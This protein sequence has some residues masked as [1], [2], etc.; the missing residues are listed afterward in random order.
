MRT[1]R[2]KFTVKRNKKSNW[3]SFAIKSKNANE[4]SWSFTLLYINDSH[5]RS[6]EMSPNDTWKNMFWYQYWYRSARRTFLDI[7][8]HISLYRSLS[9]KKPDVDQY[10]K[11]EKQLEKWKKEKGDPYVVFGPSAEGGTCPLVLVPP[12][13]ATASL[14]SYILYMIQKHVNN[15]H[16]WSHK[17][18]PNDTWKDMS[19]TGTSIVTGERAFLGFKSISLYRSLST[20]RAMHWASNF[21][22][23]K[24]V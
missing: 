17:L 19:Y 10:C 7:W 16:C 23:V 14:P 6:H 18:S 8:E 15:S 4:S 9:T 1:T 24:Q 11:N 3:I 20:N 22:Y 12:S 13:Y 5:Y 2:P 21:R